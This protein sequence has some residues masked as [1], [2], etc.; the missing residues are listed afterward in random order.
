MYHE[1]NLYAMNN[2]GGRNFALQHGRDQKDARWIL[3]LDGN[4]FFTPTGM[5]ELINQIMKEEHHSVRFDEVIKSHLII[6]MSRLLDNE[7][8]SINNTFIKTK[9]DDDLIKFKPISIEEP[10]IGFR[11]TSNQTY[12]NRMRY[13]RRSKLEFLWR[14]GAIS[15]NRDRLKQSIPESEV[16]EIELIQESS[17]GSIKRTNSTHLSSS[18]SSSDIDQDFFQAGWV[19]RL[20]SGHRKQ[21]EP[22]ELAMSRR[23]IKR[24]QA[25]IYFLNQLDQFI[26]R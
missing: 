17:F 16:E 21:E 23:S 10:Q 6:P 7:D 12:S 3:P 2:N 24:M 25:I 14:L 20:F 26:K 1:K 13:G 19:H 9:N 4:C 22:T 15:T 11:F 8:L 5:K 18:S